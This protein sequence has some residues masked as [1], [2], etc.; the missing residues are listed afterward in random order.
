A[1][2]VAA[3]RAIVVGGETDTISGFE[4]VEGANGDDIIHGGAASD[5][6]SGGVGGDELMGCGG[7]D[8]LSG[9]GGQDT[10]F[11]GAGKDM[12]SGGPDSE[13]FQFAKLTDSG[14][15]KATRDV[16]TD[17]TSGGSGGFDIINLSLIDANTKAAG[18]Q[19]FD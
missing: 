2:F 1:G 18:D 15:T 8:T 11:G 3:S 16:I 10:L 6:I 13:L 5:E 12:L 9:S 17:F 19:A 4:N 14:V 7:N